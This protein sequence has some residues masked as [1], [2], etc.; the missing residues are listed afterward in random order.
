MAIGQHECTTDA[1]AQLVQILLFLWSY[2]VTDRVSWSGRVDKFVHA[3]PSFGWLSR[4]L[5][6]TVA[7]TICGV[8]FNVRLTRQNK[9]EYTTFCIA[10][11]QC[12]KDA[13]QFGSG[14]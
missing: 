1:I 12:E 10:H 7:I 4:D 13:A 2:I 11:S 8:Y 9:C 3:S 5:E 14:L 6:H